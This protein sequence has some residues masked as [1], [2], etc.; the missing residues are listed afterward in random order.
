MRSPPLGLLRRPPRRPRAGAAARAVAAMP[1]PS[2]GRRARGASRRPRRGTACRRARRVPGWPRSSPRRR[3]R[4]A[5][6]E[7]DAIEDGRTRS[8]PA[9]G[10]A[11]HRR[12]RRSRSASRPVPNAGV[13]RVGP[14]VELGQQCPD[15]GPDSGG[16]PACDRP[17]V[18]DE[19]AVRTEGDAERDVDVER[20]R[21]GGSRR[22]DRGLGGGAE[23]RAQRSRVGSREPEHAP[24]IGRLLP[25]LDLL[26]LG[27]LRLRQPGVP[28]GREDGDPRDRVAQER[29][30]DAARD[31]RSASHRRGRWRAP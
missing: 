19:V 2:P 6:P 31:S 7:T 9:A 16:R 1:G 27:P 10:L 30:P 13:G 18:H 28:G 21:R 26:G 11:S 17:R 14:Q 15:E 24:S 8:R 29:G 5:E 4:D 25:L 23:T 12:G 3:V 20:D 22:R